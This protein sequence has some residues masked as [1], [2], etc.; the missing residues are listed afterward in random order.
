MKRVVGLVEKIKII[1]QKPVEAFALFDTGAKSTSVDIKLAG[2]AKLGPVLGMAKI[3][4]PSVKRKSRRAVVKAEI[5]IKDMKF[6]TRVNLQDRSHMTFPVIIGR[7]ILIGNFIVD[8]EKN[9]DLFK[10]R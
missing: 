6:D 4:N 1:G 3:K 9:K 10:K 7:N 5:E 2:E 8:A